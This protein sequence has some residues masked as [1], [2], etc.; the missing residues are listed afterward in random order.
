MR[1][2]LVDVVNVYSNGD[3]SAFAALTMCVRTGCQC[4]RCGRGADLWLGKPLALSPA[5]T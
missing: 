4:G 3:S 5:E 2:K 1:S